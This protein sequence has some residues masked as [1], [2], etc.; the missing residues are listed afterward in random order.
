MNTPI[1]VGDQLNQELMNNEQLAMNYE[2]S[3]MNHEPEKHFVLP[4]NL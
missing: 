1:L 4:D 2:L 3:I